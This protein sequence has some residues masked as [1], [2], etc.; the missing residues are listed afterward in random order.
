VEVV[1]AGSL[2]TV[3]V[4]KDPYGVSSWLLAVTAF[5]AHAQMKGIRNRVR[6]VLFFIIKNYTF[7]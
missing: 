4:G 6:I 3:E 5:A 2:C 7:L 1:P